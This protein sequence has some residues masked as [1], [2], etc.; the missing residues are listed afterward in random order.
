MADD[1]L[2][3]LYTD[4]KYLQEALR[5]AD[6]EAVKLSARVK[7]LEDF[8]GAKERELCTCLE[9]GDATNCPYCTMMHFT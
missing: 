7:E 1:T 4:R 6:A 9:P 3:L 2:K 5:V 8:L